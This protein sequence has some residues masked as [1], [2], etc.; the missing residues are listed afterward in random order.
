VASTVS[1]RRLDR[2]QAVA[3]QKVHHFPHRR[4]F[5]IEPFGKGTDRG[6]SLFVQGRQG[7][8]LCDPK[9]RGLKMGVIKTRDLPGCLPHGEAVAMIDPE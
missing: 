5:D 1:G 9:P 7:Q 8:K 2:D 4:P 6:A 3:L